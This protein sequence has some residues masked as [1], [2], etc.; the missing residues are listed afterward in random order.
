MISD[1]IKHKEV[2]RDFLVYM[3][4]MSHEYILKGGTS[5]MECYGLG[6]ISEDIDLD[7]TNKNSIEKII[8]SFCEERG[9]SYNVNKDTDTVKRYMIH[10]QKEGESEYEKP[11]KVEISYRKKHIDPNLYQIKDGIT[12]YNIDQLA[13]MKENAFSQRDKIRDLY[14]IVF[15][16]KN[17]WDK[18]DK[19]IQ[20]MITDGF[21]NKG[22]E[23]FDY[24]TKTQNDEM[25]NTDRLAEDVLE[26]F[27]NLGLIS[28]SRPSCVESSMDERIEQA[29]EKWEMR[30]K[31]PSTRDF[32]DNER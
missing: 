7:S 30:Q 24:I 8:S 14:D 22:L 31:N 6:R 26:V 27:D 25:I 18:L 32:Q 23:Y 3:N 5:L 13:I 28:E 11:L 1:R 29:K 10:Y 15:I 4:K 12:V 17:Y 16:C 20:N 9:Y 21:E 19:N 2:I